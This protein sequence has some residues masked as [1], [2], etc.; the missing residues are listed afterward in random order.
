[1]QR[2]AMAMADQEDHRTEDETLARHGAHE[3]HAVADTVAKAVAPLMHK[4]LQPL[5]RLI[6]SALAT[7]PPPINSHHGRQVQEGSPS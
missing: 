6:P 7:P 1:M 3:L 5:L 2:P 4:A